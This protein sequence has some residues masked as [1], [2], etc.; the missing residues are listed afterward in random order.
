MLRFSDFI[1]TWICQETR[2]EEHEPSS[3]EGG[4]NGALHHTSPVIATSGTGRWEDISHVICWRTSFVTRTPCDYI[5]PSWS[6]ASPICCATFPVEWFDLDAPRLSNP[7]PLPSPRY[8]DHDLE[9]NRPDRFG[10][11]SREW[12]PLEA[13]AV[14]L[15]E[16]NQ[17]E[18][19][20]QECR[21]QCIKDT[22]EATIDFDLVQPHK[23]LASGLLLMRSDVKEPEEHSCPD[24]LRLL[25]LVIEKPGEQDMT[26]FRK[27]GR[28]PECSS[29]FQRLGYFFVDLT[30]KQE[31]QVLEDKAQEVVLIQPLEI[32]GTSELEPEVRLSRVNR[33]GRLY[34]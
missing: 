3:D 2:H 6:W 7:K 15:I 27:C 11:L 8:I 29:V 4:K 13:I 5:A 28:L 24:T 25:G 31:H 26:N 33:V 1:T 32:H 21:L 34:E 22:C 17:G 16:I 12:L 19:K 20:E 30:E 9:P 18:G 14:Q 23:R 10:Q